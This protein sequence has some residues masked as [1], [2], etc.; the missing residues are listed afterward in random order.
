MWLASIYQSDLTPG[1]DG[2]VFSAHFISGKPA[3]LFDETTSDW[4]PT[5]SMGYQEYKTS[6]ADC[7]RY[8]RWKQKRLELLSKL[9]HFTIVIEVVFKV[10]II[11]L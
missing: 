8:H 9:K 4:I 2:H 5:V 10:V 1:P 6:D 11:I 3:S 7:D